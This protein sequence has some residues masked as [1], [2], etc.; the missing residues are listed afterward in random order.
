MLFVLL[1]LLIAFGAV[2]GVSAQGGGN[3]DAAHQ[4][5][6]GGWQT[7][8]RS[9]GSGFR[10]QGDCVSYAAQGGVLVLPVQPYSEGVTIAYDPVNTVGF[11]TFRLTATRH[12]TGSQAWSELDIYNYAETICSRSTIDAVIP[13]ADPNA[14]QVSPDLSSAGLHT[15]VTVSRRLEDVCANTVTTEPLMVEIH[16]D[17][18]ALS[19]ATFTGSTY[20]RNAQV[21]GTA[22]SYPFTCHWDT[23]VGCGGSVPTATI[24]ST[25]SP[26]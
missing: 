15:T 20:V 22:L 10:N 7:L 3:S 5:Q 1:A 26:G 17:F 21:L 25:R 6:Q 18:T 11:G 2:S 16:T 19:P 4:C 14:L 9:D 8:V 12:V 13:L 24:F 23:G